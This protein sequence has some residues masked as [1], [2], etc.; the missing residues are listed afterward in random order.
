MPK[1][2][3]FMH[4]VHITSPPVWK[5][6]RVDPENSRGFRQ[7]DMVK[8]VDGREFNDVAG[9]IFNRINRLL[10]SGP[11]ASA[12][13]V[14]LF[15]HD[16]LTAASGPAGVFPVAL[17]GAVLLGV[18]AFLSRGA[19]F[20]SPGSLLTAAGDRQGAGDEERRRYR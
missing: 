19:D 15:G 13:T 18:P 1:F 8:A 10:F 7:I 20:Q 9:G 2:L 6:K 17:V 12:R 11:T 3:L 5:H 4:E 16:A 14:S